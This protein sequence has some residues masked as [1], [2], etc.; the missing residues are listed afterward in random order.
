MFS[1]CFS[2]L[3][4]HDGSPICRHF[5]IGS[6]PD[7]R[8]KASSARSTNDYRYSSASYLGTSG[9][10]SSVGV[11]TMQYCQTLPTGT[12]TGLQGIAT[13]TL[14]AMAYN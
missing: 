4:T 8:L 7:D 6:I 9:G 3:K 13:P 14:T 10:N 1:P 2:L 5:I 12:A 11:G